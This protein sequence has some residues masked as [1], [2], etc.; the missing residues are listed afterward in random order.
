MC[1]LVDVLRACPAHIPCSRAALEPHELR[2]P[3]QPTGPACGA[4]AHK[5]STAATLLC[6]STPS[7][8]PWWKSHEIPDGTKPHYWRQ[9]VPF[10]RKSSMLAC[11]F[12]HMCGYHGG[13]GECIVQKILVCQHACVTSKYSCDVKSLFALSRSSV[14]DNDRLGRL[15]NTETCCHL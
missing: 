6:V 2:P 11:R 13:A 9:M 1:G 7:L 8:N 3:A 15:G 14:S 5:S 4:R 12:Y 10:L